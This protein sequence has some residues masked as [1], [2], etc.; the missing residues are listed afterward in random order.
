MYYQLL[1]CTK[2]MALSFFEG[3]IFLTKNILKKHKKRVHHI[4]YCSIFVMTIYV[5]VHLLTE[6][7]NISILTTK[8]KTT[9]SH[10]RKMVHYI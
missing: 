8:V 9:Y 2:G 3:A 4:I 1:K 5:I 10:S 7:K 6:G